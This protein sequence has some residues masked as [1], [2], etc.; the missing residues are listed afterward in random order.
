MLPCYGQKENTRAA[1]ERL[2]KAK[3]N[4]GEEKSG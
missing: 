1:G 2:G 4:K 3:K